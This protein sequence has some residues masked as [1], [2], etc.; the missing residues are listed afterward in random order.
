MRK[1]MRVSHPDD[2]AVDKAVHKLPGGVGSSFAR[3]G[4]KMRR[5]SGSA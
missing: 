3:C 5:N 4:D 2:Q 1:A